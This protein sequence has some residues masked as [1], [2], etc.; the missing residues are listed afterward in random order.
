[1]NEE[2]VQSA[3]AIILNAGDAR[4]ACKEALD[5]ISEFD[6]EKAEE[7]LKESH[8]KITAAHKVQLMRFRAKQEA[9]KVSIHCCLLMHKIL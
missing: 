7:K 1:M 5:A 3:M 8:E 2:V 4:V 9:K 6:F